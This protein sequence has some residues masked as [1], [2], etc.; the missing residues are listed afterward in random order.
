MKKKA[1]W[2][3]LLLLLAAAGALLLL[4]PGR[5]GVPWNVLVITLDTTRADRLG[6][7]GY[8]AARTPNLDRLAAEGILLENGYT[9]VPL[10]LP[11][12]SVLFTGRYPI[13]NN[14]RNN[15][16]YFLPEGE[17]TLAEVLRDRGYDTRAVIAAFVLLSKFGL[18]QGFAVYDD[19]LD[20]HEM[21]RNYRSE[22]PAAMVHDK[23]SAW[24]DPAEE[25]PF[26]YWVHFYDPHTPYRPPPEF[27]KLYPAGPEGLYDGEIAYMDV[28]VGRVIEALRQRGLLER[29]LVV[30]AGDHGEAFGEHV[31]Q[32]HGIFCYE[33]SL[34]VPLFFH[35]PGLL[36]KP[37]RVEARVGL[38][39]VMPTV[40]D[41]L[42]VEVPA[43]VQGRSFLSLLKGESEKEERPLYFESMYGP[44]E[45]N[46]A[47][48][49]GL[50]R[51][52]YKYVSLPDP[53]LYDLS[54][55]RGEKANLF[56]RK[57]LVARDMD[58]RLAR[59]VAGHSQRGHETR[60]ALSEGDKEQ[61][62]ALGYISAFS[63]QGAT[64]LDPKKGVLIDA[65]LK[66][67]SQRIAEKKIEEAEAE[68]RQLLSENPGLKMPH[69]YNLQYKLY[70]SKGDARTAL[71]FLRQAIDEFPDVETFRQTLALALFDMKMYDRAEKRC[72]EMLDKNPRNT[73]ARILLG[74][75]REKQ[76]RPAEA[77]EH[78]ALALAIEPQ[79]VSLRIKHAELLITLKKFAEAV[80]EYD[81]LLENEEA[82]A[83]SE[84]L[85]KVALLNTRYGSMAAAEGMLARA[86][87]IKPEGKFFFNYA[88]VLAKNGKMDL[89]LAQ[90]ETALGRHSEQLS[91]EQRQI[92]E[93]ALAAWR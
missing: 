33:E 47:P 76:G 2:G 57:N 89:A 91:A 59:F 72:N 30:V 28:W 58:K 1:R 92:A 14:V 53:E 12:H 73:R 37:R 45:M 5:R 64:A 41:L 27:A 74:E 25:R 67:V 52:T 36:G 68:L 6:A 23:F 63:S 16:S 17:T 39:D 8:A 38:V 43:A 24:L 26:F 93:K 81:R 21:I 65:R 49:T 22:I 87:A 69:V 55:D 4:R 42:D 46:W 9:S 48:L 34:R 11:S 90:M 86:V 32:G 66:K 29:T 77:Q 61:L 40:L 31:E 80:A 18:N 70:M 10:T 62:Q 19:S 7:Y 75:I 50:L 88:L 13:A 79:N 56:L 35:A 82:A 78:Y 60:R 20:T 84:L 44:E 71:D 51:E 85:L 3:I 15:G 83:Q 54:A